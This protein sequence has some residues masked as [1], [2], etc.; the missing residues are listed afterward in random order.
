MRSRGSVGKTAEF[1]KSARI[2]GFDVDPGKLPCKNGM[3]VDSLE[4]RTTTDVRCTQRARAD[5]IEVFEKEKEGLAA[6]AI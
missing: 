1:R 5:R 3:L 6:A 4:A 2:F